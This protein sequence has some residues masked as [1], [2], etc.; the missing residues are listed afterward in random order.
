MMKCLNGIAVTRTSRGGSDR[1]RYKC[2]SDGCER[3]FSSRKYLGLHMEKSHDMKF[4]SWEKTC[5]ECQLVFE[6][7]GDYS[8][9]V[10]THSCN[11][12]CEL[13]KL[14]FKTDSKLQIHKEKLHKVGEDRPFLCTE[15]SCGA[16]FKRSEHLRGHTLYK[17]SGRFYEKYLKLFNNFNLNRR[18]KIR[19]QSLRSKIPTTW[20]IQR[21]YEV[22]YR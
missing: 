8:V 21:T 7:T 2:F 5:I 6:T 11:F 9:H 12:V 19:M 13:C 15:T 3:Q 20:W 18:K 16:R 14:R 10:K 22:K 1:E 4:D 17:H